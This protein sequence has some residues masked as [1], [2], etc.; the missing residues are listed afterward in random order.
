M[1]TRISTLMATQTLMADETHATITMLRAVLHSPEGEGGTAPTK[2]AADGVP[3]AHGA[4]DVQPGEPAATAAGPEKKARTV[5]RRLGPSPRLKWL[6]ERKRNP[7]T[8]PS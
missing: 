8:T 7:P 1:N 2:R 6:R 5:R 3:D 4:N